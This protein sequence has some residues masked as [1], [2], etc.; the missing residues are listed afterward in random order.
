MA[1]R[2]A[3]DDFDDDDYLPPPRRGAARARSPVLLYAGL[4]VGA[5]VVIGTLLVF[6]ARGRRAA[7]HAE[8]RA[9]AES[10]AAREQQLA[11]ASRPKE[12]GRPPLGATG[13]NWE[14][15]IGT[16]QREPA[17]E[18]DTN[19]P[20]QFE[21][22]RDLTALFTRLNSD[23]VPQAIAA[24]VEVFNDQG[25]SLA[26]RLHVTRGTYAYWFKLPPD[27]TL[28]LKDVDAGVELEFAR[29]K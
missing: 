5:V 3:D 17:G 15:A 13:A 6:M 21:F 8:I 23:G 27:G 9:V 29:M 1:R 18:N 12:V 14:K 4:A 19:Y 7:E 26:M 22:R 24:R 28:V 10:Q 25:D 11:L 20:Y 2:D 16:W